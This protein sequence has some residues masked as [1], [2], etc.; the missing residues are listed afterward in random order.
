MKKLIVAA[1]FVFATAS[2][3]FAA[4]MP[5]KAPR[6]YAPV[7]N[8]TGLYIGAHGGYGWADLSIN[9]LTGTTSLDGWFG[10]GQIGYNWQAPGSNWVLG[11]EA[12]ISGGDISQTASA[13]GGGVTVSETTKLESFGSVRGRIGYAFDRSLAYF[14]GG[15]AWGNGNFSVSAAIP[16]LGVA[17][18]ASSSQTHTG[19]VLG[20]GLEMA[21]NQNWTWGIEYQHVSFDSATYFGLISAGYDVDTVRLKVNYLFH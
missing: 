12:D 3:S 15:W 1:A 20:G 19:W 14:T 5:A 10:G 16:A 17:A 2:T 11:L 21:I 8:W 6:A 9:G 18:A 7:W 13:T 4:D